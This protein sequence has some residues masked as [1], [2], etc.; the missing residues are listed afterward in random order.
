MSVQMPLPDEITRPL[1][2]INQVYF[3]DPARTLEVPQGKV[4]VHQGEECYRMFLV[5]KGLFAAF[6]QA[7]NVAGLD[8]PAESSSRGYEAFRAEAGSYVCVQ[9]FFSRMYR[10]SYN[11]VAL[12]DSEVCYIDDTT[13]AVDAPFYGPFERQF[14]PVIIHELAARNSRIFTKAAEKEEAL[15]LVQRSEMSAT[16]AQLSAGIAH[17]LNNAVG[18]LSRRTEFVAQSLEEY[19][20]AEDKCN[21]ELFRAGVEDNSYASA[22][23]LRS[24]A[25]YYERELELPQEA[26]KVMAHMYPDTELG[27][28]QASR[29]IRNLRRNYR[30]W[31]LGHDLRD[32]KIAS[33]LATG[34]VRAVKMLGGGKST[35]EPGVDVEQTIKDALNLLHN[36]LKHLT[37]QTTFSPLPPITAD[38]TELVQVWTNIIKNAYDALMQDQTP[39][40]RI[41]ISTGILHTEGHRLLPSD[42]ITVTIS[43]NGPAIA[44]ENITKIFHPNFTTKKLGLDFGLGLGLSI[45]RRVIDSY[46]AA[47][48]VRSTEE[49][50]SFIINIPTTQIH[51]EN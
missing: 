34:I 14:L 6:R 5:K 4:L 38:A 13:M 25:R 32:M 43:N 48:E 41:C 28:K 36:Q 29:F 44:E 45:V 27:R 16:L 19:L 8:L 40:P 21:A 31:E 50:T 49:E 30:F 26:A 11:I 2:R 35:R 3:S 22:S 42:Y 20:E 12:E 39:N 46:R 23:D 24:A 15:R 18:V 7:E 47:I 9:S 37:V 17:E 10:S 33:K 1:R 51:G